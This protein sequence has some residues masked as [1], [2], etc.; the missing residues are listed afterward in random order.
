MVAALNKQIEAGTLTNRLG[1]TVEQPLESG[2]VNEDES[3][4]Y[5]VRGE[6][7]VLVADQ[8]IE[9]QQTSD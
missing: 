9:L 6:I 4:L 7:M 1:Q 3:L 2:L 8:A 5:A